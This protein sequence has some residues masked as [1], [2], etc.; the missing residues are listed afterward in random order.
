[1]ALPVTAWVVFGEPRRG[2]T[3]LVCLEGLATKG[4]HG[5]YPLPNSMKCAPAR[6]LGKSDCGACGAILAEHPT[7]SV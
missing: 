1:M 5:P 6:G 4:G 3:Y 7:N 2:Q